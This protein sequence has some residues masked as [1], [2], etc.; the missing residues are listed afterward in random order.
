[1]LEE[2]SPFAASYRYMRDV[3]L[4][5]AGDDISSTL[6]FSANVEGDARRYNSPTMREIAVVF[7]GQDDAPPANRDIVVYPKDEAAYRVNERNDLADPMTYA[8]LF[9]NG[10]A[11]WSETMQ[12]EKKHRSPKYTR[13]TTGHRQARFLDHLYC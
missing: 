5:G 7:G 9:P 11:G 4:E 1:M 2:I 3:A 13:L 8:P 12:H 6:G 10:V